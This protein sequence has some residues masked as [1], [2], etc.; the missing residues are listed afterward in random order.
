MFHLHTIQMPDL[1]GPSIPDRLVSAYNFGDIFPP[2]A[3]SLGT[4][5]TLV[6]GANYSYPP[7]LAPTGGVP[8]VLSKGYGYVVADTIVMSNGF[9]LT[10]AGVTAGQI[11]SWTVT[12]QATYA[13]AATIT[14][15]GWNYFGQGN[16]VSTS[17]KGV[18]AVSGWNATLRAASMKVTTAA[19]GAAGTNY[20]TNDVLFFPNGISL[21]VTASAGAITSL[22]VTTAGAYVGSGPMPCANVAPIAQNTSN[23]AASGALVNLNWGVN[24]TIIDDGGYYATIP[25]GVSV[26]TQTG[27]SGSNGNAITPATVAAGAAVAAGASSFFGVGPFPEGI[28]PSYG[29]FSSPSTYAAILANGTNQVGTP[30]TSVQ[31]VTCAVNAKQPQ[32]AS[33]ALTPVGAGAASPSTIQGGYLDSIIHG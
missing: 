25:T 18:G 6:A 23:A 15:N 11:T 12:Q 20:T 8:S 9:K 1:G 7:L 28:S 29:V 27:D 24:A 32:Y 4:L 2:A 33:V 26:T 22:A 14:G 17:G 19:V 21:T 16:Q 5:G 3:N 10:V 13:N 30:L 31:I